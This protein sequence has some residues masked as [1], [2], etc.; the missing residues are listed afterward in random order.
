LH[1]IAL[2]RGT[3]SPVH[4]VLIG[5]GALRADLEAMSRDLGISTHVHFTGFR[6]DVPKLMR[7]LHMFL[8]TSRTEG[9]GT[10]ILDAFASDVPVVATRAGGIPEIVHHGE[11][12]LL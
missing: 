3:D 5:E 11:S 12:G 4:G 7:E 10:S 6:N 8:I 2:L 9:L 1:T